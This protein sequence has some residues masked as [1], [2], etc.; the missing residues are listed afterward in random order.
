MKSP[1]IAGTL[2]LSEKMLNSDEQFLHLFLLS[3]FF[4][5]CFFLQ[6]S[7]GSSSASA[8]L[9]AMR[10]IAVKNERIEEVTFDDSVNISVT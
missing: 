9:A 5:Q 2:I 10:K 6:R 8:A 1:L 7:F 3:I 4:I